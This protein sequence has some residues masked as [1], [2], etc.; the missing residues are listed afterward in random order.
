MPGASKKPVF[1]SGFAFLKLSSAEKTPGD[2]P[3]HNRF[4]D[5][6]QI[7]T[8]VATRQLSSATVGWRV[9]PYSTKFIMACVLAAL[10]GISIASGTAISHQKGPCEIRVIDEVPGGKELLVYMA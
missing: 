10:A 7:F 8:Q 2:M 9:M 1:I 3:C 4:A 5:D 6:R